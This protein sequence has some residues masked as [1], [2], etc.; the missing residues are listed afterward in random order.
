MKRQFFMCV[1]VLF[2][3]V[4]MNAYGEYADPLEN[5]WVLTLEEHW[6]GSEPIKGNGM[7]FRLKVPIGDT[8]KTVFDLWQ[9]DIPKET[10]TNLVLHPVTFGSDDPSFNAAE[11]AI[12]K[13]AVV[14]KGKVE[15]TLSNCKYPYIANPRDMIHL[16]PGTPHKL[17]AMEDAVIM[18]YC[19]G[20]GVSR[21][22]DKTFIRAYFDTAATDD[23][24]VFPKDEDLICNQNLKDDAFIFPYDFPGP[25]H[26]IRRSL[27]RRGA[28]VTM[29]DPER[30]EYN[31]H[32]K[33]AGFETNDQMEFIEAEY[34]VM[35]FYPHHH[36]VLVECML[37]THKEIT[38]WVGNGTANGEINVAGP[39]YEEIP[40]KAHFARNG[41]GIRMKPG[42]VAYVPPG[43][44]HSM[45]DAEEG[46][47]WILTVNPTGRLKEKT[48]GRTNQ[49]YQAPEP[50]PGS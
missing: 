4:Q 46:N 47:I 34:F 25:N 13:T 35:D 19:Y 32:F 3:S 9:M 14:I 10:S 36:E 49:I 26:E 2:F 31:Y 15:V 12:Y 40:A 17:T 28:I 30:P 45:D 42:Y 39:H 23:F 48:A 44:P 43:V 6:P 7:I 41:D 37:I 33:V 50:L 1:C 29:D 20:K 5:P 11:D 16:M 8:E 22:K 27:F 21:D 18:V 24:T 38:Y